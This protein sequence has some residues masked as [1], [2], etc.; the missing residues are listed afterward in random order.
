MATPQFILRE[1]DET[2]A[3]DTLRHFYILCPECRRIIHDGW[4]VESA[5]PPIRVALMSCTPCA[6][7]RWN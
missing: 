2:P 7:R 5:I 1:H 6:Q 3:G 4:E